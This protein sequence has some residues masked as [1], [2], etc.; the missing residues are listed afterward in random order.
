MLSTCARISAKAIAARSG[1]RRRSARRA[2]A[3]RR[4]LSAAPARAMRG[5]AMQLEVSPHL[6]GQRVEVLVPHAGLHVSSPAIHQAARGNV[7]G[8]GASAERGVEAG[9]PAELLPPG[10]V[11]RAAPCGAAGSKV[12]LYAR[13]LEVPEDTVG[14]SGGRLPRS[15]HHLR[16]LALLIPDQELRLLSCTDVSCHASAIELLSRVNRA[17]YNSRSAPR[18]AARSRFVG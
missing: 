12:G 10:S 7:C 11:T 4:E 2:R 3:C 13:T 16:L 8:Q 14:V 17:R 5:C 1:R 15:R 9:Y 6:P 18:P